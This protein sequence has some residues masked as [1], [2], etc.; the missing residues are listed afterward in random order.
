MAGWSH[1]VDLAHAGSLVRVLP[2]EGG[3]AVDLVIG[4]TRPLA[5]TPWA[6]EVVP[7]DVRAPDE[8][9]WVARWRGGWQP[10][11]PSTGHP[12]SGDPGQ[13]FHGAASQARWTPVD[14]SADQVLLEWADGSGL[15]AR[16]R[17]VLAEHSLGVRGELVNRSSSPR[18]VAV[19]EHLVL[20]DDL[21]GG[22]EVAVDAPATATLAPLDYDGR[23]DGAHVGWPGHPEHRWDRVGPGTPARVAALVDVRPRQVTVRAPR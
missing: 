6:D 1:A 13:S 10:C 7:A 20:G 19:A 3:V 11:L 14:R 9:A 8:P 16:R 15:V 18:A 5:R 23:P 4:G 21:L 17:W 12:D 2:D 22:D